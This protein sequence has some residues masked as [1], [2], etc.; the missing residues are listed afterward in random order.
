MRANSLIASVFSFL[1]CCFDKITAI[2]LCLWGQSKISI[3]DLSLT[4][5]EDRNKNSACLQPPAHIGLN[6]LF[7]ALTVAGAAGRGQHAY[8]HEPKDG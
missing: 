6:G 5:R 3:L 4:K 8:Q 1:S 7:S 2:M